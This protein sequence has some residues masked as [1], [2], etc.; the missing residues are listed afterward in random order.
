MRSR[1]PPRSCSFRPWPASRTRPQVRAYLWDGTNFGIQ[2]SK[3]PSDPAGGA[4]ARGFQHLDPGSFSLIDHDTDF[5]GFKAGQFV[6][7]HSPGAADAILPPPSLRTSGLTLAHDTRDQA[8]TAAFARS[9]EIFTGAD[10]VLFGIDVIRG[11]RIDIFDGRPQARSWRSLC[12]RQGIYTFT[13]TPNL[14]REI[15]DEGFVQTGVT[16]G[17]ADAAGVANYKLSEGVFRWEGWS[18]S[19]PHPMTALSR[20]PDP[21][22]ALPPGP[23]MLRPTDLASRRLFRPPAA[24]CRPCALD[25]R[26]ARA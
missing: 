10:Q 15:A 14:S 12:Q 20:D 6:A 19:A 5:S 23:S 16:H 7:G 13:N 25:R 8:L 11:F 4:I 2:P 26:I 3:D 18:L 24:R 22:K 9:K 21:A 1:P 17:G